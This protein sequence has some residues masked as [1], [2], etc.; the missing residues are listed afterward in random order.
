MDWHLLP[1]FSVFALYPVDDLFVNLVSSRVEVFIFTLSVS[2]ILRLTA[3][4]FMF[5][6]HYLSFT[7]LKK[8]F[9]LVSC[10]RFRVVLLYLL[11]RPNLDFIFV[12]PLD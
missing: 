10:F 5:L 12:K 3:H 1:S 8:V 11:A 2:H 6:D 7:F 4:I 9:E